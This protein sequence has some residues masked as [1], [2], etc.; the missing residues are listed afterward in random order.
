MNVLQFFLYL[1]CFIKL[2]NHIEMFGLFEGRD[3]NFNIYIYQLH[4]SINFVTFVSVQSENG[5][6]INILQSEHTHT[7]LF[8]S[9]LKFYL[10]FIN[11]IYGSYIDMK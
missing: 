10:R 1:L 4:V 2:D 6:C 7:L 5:I 8:L 3:V 11:S 9:R